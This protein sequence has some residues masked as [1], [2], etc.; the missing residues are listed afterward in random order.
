MDL[1]ELFNKWLTAKNRIEELQK[2]IESNNQKAQIKQLSF[3]D[4]IQVYDVNEF[5]TLKENTEKFAIEQKNLIDVH[6]VLND[7]IIGLFQNNFDGKKIRLQL[8]TGNTY[9]PSRPGVVYLD[10]E[11]ASLQIK[12]R[13]GDS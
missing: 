13:L 7:E 6:S 3:S 4:V 12:Y 8:P 9:Q 5:L 2:I 10:Y 11:G 1:Q